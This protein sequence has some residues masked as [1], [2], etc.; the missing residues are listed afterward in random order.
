MGTRLHFLIGDLKQRRRRD[1][2]DKKAIDLD[3]LI[4]QN[5]NF[6]RATRLFVHFFA[7]FARLQRENPH[8]FVEGDITKQQF[9]FLFLNFD[10]TN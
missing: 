2:N 6:A 4:W 5:N 8:V 9:S 7:V 10:T 1:E 3:S